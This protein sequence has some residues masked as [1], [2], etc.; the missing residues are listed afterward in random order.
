MHTHIGQPQ[1]L[2]AHHKRG[3]LLKRQD[4]ISCIFIAQTDPD[5]T[6]SHCDMHR[7]QSPIR[8]LEPPTRLWTTAE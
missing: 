1:R 2:V 8:I 7:Q 3:Q 4:T 6:T 5:V